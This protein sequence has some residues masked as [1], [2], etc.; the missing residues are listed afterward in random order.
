MRGALVRIDRPIGDPRD[1]SSLRLRA[2]GPCRC[3]SFFEHPHPFCIDECKHGYYRHGMKVNVAFLS[4]DVGRLFR[5][6]FGVAARK[7]GVTG[8]QWRALAAI[9]RSPG[10][11]QQA[12]A[13]WLEVEAITAARMIDR[14]EKLDLVER[15][16]DPA[17][18]RRWCL[19]L[20][21]A[22]EDL[23]G[24]MGECARAV[25]DEAVAGLTEA[26]QNQLLTLLER[27]RTNLSDEI[28][29]EAIPA[30]G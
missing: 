8:P 26:E 27:V 11:T 9:Q 23:M 24:R 28:P 10:T 19:Y 13:S 3:E 6:R 25:I 29:A 20:T 18:R 17:D 21:P 1:Q 5:K 2:I 14:L 16:D 12:L 15:R 22:A 4:S 7:F 30:H